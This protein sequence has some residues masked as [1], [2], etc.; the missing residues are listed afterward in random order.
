MDKSN[1]SKVVL[2][3]DDLEAVRI[4]VD[5]L[6]GFN[7]ED[8]ERV[9]R[10]AKEKLGLKTPTLSGEEFPS[11]VKAPIEVKEQGLARKDIKTFIQEKTPKSERQ[12]AAVIAYYY[13]FEASPNERKDSI[14]ASDLKE[15]CRQANVN[16]PKDAIRTLINAN[17]A[18]YLDKAG[19]P[20]KYK[21][22]TVGENLVAMILP[23]GNSKITLANGRKNNKKKNKK[24]TR[25]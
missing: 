9:I 2:P 11:V 10:W 7:V 14:G 12:L 5:A 23:A 1:I 15:A 22:N 4:I 16:R 18:G 20:G 6:E 13:A 3:K 8:S 19:E 24:K 21:I 25:K 17:H